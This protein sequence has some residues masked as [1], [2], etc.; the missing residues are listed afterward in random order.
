MKDGKVFDTISIE[1]PNPARLGQHQVKVTGV[2]E[3]TFLRDLLSLI[4]PIALF[5]GVWWFVLRRMGQSQGF[6]RSARA[7]PRSTWRRKP[8]SPPWTWRAW[9]KLG[10]EL[11]EVVEFL[12]T[13]T[14]LPARRIPKGILLVGPPGTGKTLLAKAVAEN[15][16][17]RSSR[18]AARNS[19][20]CSW[21]S[22]ARVR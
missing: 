16:A 10:Q 8:A 6:I 3:S 7:R 12:K 14:S 13:P 21:E 1:D 15:P 22:A 17:C 4:V 20:R 19:W 5:F 2:I 9:M 18:S 11:E